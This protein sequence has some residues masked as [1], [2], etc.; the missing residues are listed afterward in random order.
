MSEHCVKLSRLLDGVGSSFTFET[1]IEVSG[2]ALDSRKVSADFFFAAVNGTNTNGEEYIQNAIEAGASVIAV[3][4][5]SSINCEATIYSANVSFVKVDNLK[6]NLGIIASNFY[7]NP[8]KAIHMV[9]VTGTNGKSTV[10][11]LAGQ[12]FKGFEEKVG[13]VGTLGYGVVG[14]KVISTGLTTPDAFL[15]QKILF[16]FSQQGVT[17]VCMEVSSHAIDQA[18]IAGIDFN[19]VLITNISH[20]H[21]DYHGTFSN[22]ANI[23]LSFINSCEHKV[24]HSS[25]K[26]LIEKNP[27]KINPVASPCQYYGYES[28]ND[29]YY[30]HVQFSLSGTNASCFVGEKAFDIKTQLI[31]DYNLDNIVAA[32]A[33]VLDR[34]KCEQ[35]DYDKL[36]NTLA[37]L[38]SVKGRLEKVSITDENTDLPVVIIDFAHTPDALEKV[39]RA[40]HPHVKNELWL[41]FGC[42][43]DRDP[44]KRPLM[45]EIAEKFADKVI[46]TSDNPRTESKQ[47]IVNDIQ[48][49]MSKNTAI[50]ELDREKA[51][52]FAIKNSDVDDCIIVAGKGHEEYQIIGVEKKIFSDVDISKAFLSAR[53]RNSGISLGEAR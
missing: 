36:K 22:Y 38:V 30:S 15:L 25:V 9:G 28:E 2:I 44:L 31:G 35:F 24:A 37:G 50:V 51:I 19:T 48:S 34:Y 3:D 21:L 27:L 10:V 29:L 39:L 12:L 52:G 42:G 20:D 47:A 1:N 49:G 7:G 17:C 16:E 14:E 45:G 13:V 4:S 18:R 8:S 53:A 40:I 11:H 43:G 32:I 23:K 33:I 6:Q 26:D 41:V 46:V 5:Q